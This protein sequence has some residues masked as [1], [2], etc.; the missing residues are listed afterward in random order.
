MTRHRH[1][2][3]NGCGWWWCIS[4]RCLTLNRR[5]CLGCENDTRGHA[6]IG[7]A[8]RT[9]ARCSTY[10]FADYRNPRLMLTPQC[11]I[12]RHVSLRGLAESGHYL[13]APELIRCFSKRS[14]C[15]C[16]ACNVR[17]DAPAFIPPTMEELARIY[18]IT[19]ADLDLVF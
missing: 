3:V 14:K 17:R 1:D 16:N 9:C 2:C 15:K 5:L 18:G 4:P 10:L 13:Y 8:R 7:D 6:H 12:C 11:M 19:D